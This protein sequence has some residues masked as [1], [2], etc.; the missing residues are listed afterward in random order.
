MHKRIVMTA[1]VLA[2]P[3]VFWSCTITPEATADQV[4][5][6]LVAADFKYNKELARERKVE[7]KGSLYES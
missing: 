3:F 6:M 7:Y 5:N 2:A 1:L 4:E